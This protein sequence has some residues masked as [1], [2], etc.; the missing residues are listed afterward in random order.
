MAVGTAS[1]LAGWRAGLGP[2]VAWDRELV[3]EAGH[4]KHAGEAGTVGAPEAVL[5]VELDRLLA[6]SRGEQP[7]ALVEL[8]LCLPSAMA[9]LRKRLE[10]VARR[11]MRTGRTGQPTQPG[12]RLACR[13][14]VPLSEQW[15]AGAAGVASRGGGTD[16]AVDPSRLLDRPP[17]PL[18][19]TRLA[20]L[21]RG[22]RVM[23]TG[24]GGSIGA[25]LARQV[26]AH[27]PA[28]LQLLERSENALFE[29]D[30][31]LRARH[32]QLDVRACLHDVTHRRRT[33]EKLA[34]LRPDVV[35]HAAAHKHVPMMEE[36]P[37]DAV[38]NNLFGTRHVAEA[39]AAVGCQSF[40]LIS[41]DKAVNPSS[42]MGATKRLAEQCIADLQRRHATRFAMV[43]FGNVLGSA[44]SV[45]PIWT[46][47]LAEGGP[48]T[49]T[50]PRMTRYFMTIPEAAGLVLTAAALAAAGPRASAEAD[51]FLLDMG[52]PVQVLDLAERFLR[53][54]GLEPG[55]DVAIH[56]TGA[57]PGE[58][59]VEELSGKG[60]DL[61]PTAH[62]RIR[63]WTTPV[64]TAP[65]MA[66]TLRTFERLRAVGG[67]PAQP[68][69]GSD[70]AVVAAAI[71]QAVPEMVPALPVAAR[72]AAAAAGGR[73]AA[74]PARGGDAL[75][76]PPVA[77]TPQAVCPAA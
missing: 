8:T 39:A 6:Q 24:A 63:R 69:A 76:P 45:L 54:Q 71:R 28:Q 52:Q 42:V 23:V 43:R 31:Q 11:S 58:K 32:P 37:A 53:L 4:L 50:D 30:R 10:Q 56:I 35:L 2:G 1:A 36:H 66:R 55:R 46:R 62:P 3:L 18:D 17:V 59:L 74:P 29:A 65:V 13:T 51:V 20:R 47:Q 12:Q 26:A 70:R 34:E 16:A 22:R 7:P 64:C 49:V 40:V 72:P 9:G 41:T 14:V 61:H 57:R 25:E 44:C 19:R 38:E 5:E 68:W 27:R 21:L 48:L 75:V 33:H 67:D 77:S 73:P 15:A 60:E